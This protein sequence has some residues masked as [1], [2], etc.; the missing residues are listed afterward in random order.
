MLLLV[1]LCY[2]VVGID[3]PRCADADNVSTI[4]EH[5]VAYWVLVLTILIL[6]PVHLD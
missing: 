1:E 5:F 3:I 6:V 2:G 4:C